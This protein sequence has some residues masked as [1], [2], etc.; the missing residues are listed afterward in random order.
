MSLGMEQQATGL[1]WEGRKFVDKQGNIGDL[2][3]SMRE[4]QS[5]CTLPNLTVTQWSRIH[6]PMQET[7]V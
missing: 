2:E 5:P 1:V 7:W 4:V 3:L 6:L